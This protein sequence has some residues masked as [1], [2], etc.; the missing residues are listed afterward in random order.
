ML[1]AGIFSVATERIGF[2]I[3]QLRVEKGRGR[4]ALRCNPSYKDNR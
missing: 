1:A 3:M 4:I 2:Q